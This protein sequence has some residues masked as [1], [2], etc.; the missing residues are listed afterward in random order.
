[1]WDTKRTANTG[2]IVSR[3]MGTRILKEVNSMTGTEIKALRKKL[4]I[5]Q[6][7]LADAI[8]VDRVTV[9]RWETDQRRPSNLAK[10]QLAR[11]SKKG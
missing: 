5:T 1:M 8:G 9:A 11:L 4:K 7:G 2:I 6:Q 10:K 3:V